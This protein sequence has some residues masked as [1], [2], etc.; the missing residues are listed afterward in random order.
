[1]GLTI[2]EVIHVIALNQPKLLP[3]S[4]QLIGEYGI[5]GTCTSVPTWSAAAAW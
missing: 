2:A 5:R 1:M 4:S 3:V